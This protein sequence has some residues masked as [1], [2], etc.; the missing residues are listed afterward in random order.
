MKDV[1]PIPV[2]ENAMIYY[3]VVRVACNVVPLFDYEN[4]ETL[5]S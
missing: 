2:N 3:F 4:L 1:G 5:R